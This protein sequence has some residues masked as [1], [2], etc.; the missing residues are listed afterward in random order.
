MSKLCVD[1]AWYHRATDEELTV[2]QPADQCLCAEAYVIQEHEREHRAPLQ[3][4]TVRTIGGCG[5]VDP[6]WWEERGEE[7]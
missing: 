7:E 2:G 4:Y 6:I 5:V 3:C 1:C